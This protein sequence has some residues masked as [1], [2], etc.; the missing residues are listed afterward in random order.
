MLLS[1]VGMFV[2]KCCSYVMPDYRD[3]SNGVMVHLLILRTFQKWGTSQN[4]SYFDVYR[5]VVSVLDILLWCLQVCRQCSWHFA[6]MFTGVSS[7]FLTFCFDV[8][9]CVVSVRDILCWV[10]FINSCSLTV[11]A[12]E[13]VAMETETKH[14]LLDPAVS[15]IHGACLVFLDGLG[16]GENVKSLFN[17]VNSLEQR[18]DFDGLQSSSGSWIKNIRLSTFWLSLKVLNNLVKCSTNRAIELP[19]LYLSKHDIVHILTFSYSLSVTYTT[20][21]LMIYCIVNHLLFVGF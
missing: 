15:L 14:N 4:M 7:V 10:N 13:S 3:I 12:D 16:A 9:R 6:L 17:I 21:H 19:G 8:F 5:C 18:L 2:R 11:K 20:S 1:N